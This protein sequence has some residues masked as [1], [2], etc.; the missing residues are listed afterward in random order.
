MFSQ[1]YLLST[2]RNYSLPALSN[3]GI[4][5]TGTSI[6]NPVQIAT[7][8]DNSLRHR[9]STFTR[10]S[11]DIMGVP[12]QDQRG[13]ATAREQNGLPKLSPAEFRMY[14]HIAERMDIFVCFDD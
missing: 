3:T 8:F 11:S 1:L 10:R 7:T 4:L 12:R 6:Q 14:N 2:G 5:M 9:P 13:A